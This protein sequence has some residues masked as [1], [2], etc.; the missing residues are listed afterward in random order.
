MPRSVELNPLLI[1]P[2]GVYVFRKDG[3]QI[4][5][6]SKE[7]QT[8]VDIYEQ[9]YAVRKLNREQKL[10]WIKT[11]YP[12]DPVKQQQLRTKLGV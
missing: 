3:S 5:P 10:E 4:D 7:G 2:N 1:F 12:R 6:K 11:T 9:Q 8:I